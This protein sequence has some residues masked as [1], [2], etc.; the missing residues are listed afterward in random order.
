MEISNKTLA[1]L[2]VVTIAISLTGTI[3][4]LNTL[5]E[6]KLTG[7]ATYNDTG[8]AQVIISS[9]TVLRFIVNTIDFGTGSVNSTGYTNCTLYVNGSSGTSINRT[10]GCINFNTT[11]GGPLVLENDGTTYINVTI[12][13]STNAAEF[14][15]GTSPQFQYQIQ[16]NETGSCLSG[17]A[18]TTWTDVVKGTVTQICGNMSY[19]DANDTLR[20][21][22]LVTIPA[23]APPG[24]RPNAIFTAQG[25]G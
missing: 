3:L 23:D 9:S 20:M 17:A 5:Q 12:N 22:I 19:I 24:T 7:Y 21:G 10:A 8:K 6:S 13:A 16:E 25:T 15:N 18:A 14:I 1:V 2:L 11:A 4:S